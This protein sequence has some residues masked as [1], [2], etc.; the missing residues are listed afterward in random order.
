MK[1]RSET[2]GNDEAT[3]EVIIRSDNK[4]LVD[5]TALAAVL[6]YVGFVK[7]ED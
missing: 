4:V 3:V 6:Q 2:W 5:Y 7:L 1:R